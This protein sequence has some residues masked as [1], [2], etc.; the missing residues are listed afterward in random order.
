MRGKRKL[1]SVRRCKTSSI[2]A[3]VSVMLLS[4]TTLNPSFL[5]VA[6]AFA[7][8][9]TSSLRGMGSF[10]FS[11]LNHSR[12]AYDQQQQQQQQHVFEPIR[13]H[14]NPRSLTG[15]SQELV[16][17][18]VDKVNTSICTNSFVSLSLRGVKTRKSSRKKGRNDSGDETSETLRGS[19]RQVHGRLVR[20]GNEKKGGQQNIEDSLRLQLTLK[21]HLATD[22]VK[23]IDLAD[24][25]ETLTSLLLDA[26]E[27]SEWGVQAIRSNPLQ[28]ALLETTEAVW[29]LNLGSKPSI[30]RQQVKTGNDPISP[31]MSHDREKNVPL[32][33]GAEFLRMLGVTTTDG[34]PRPG[35]AS[36][37]RQ[38][39]RFVEIVA[40]LVEKTVRDE[41]STISVLDMGC[42]RGY[43]T[44]SLHSYLSE[45]YGGAALVE[46]TGVDV[47]PKLI[48]EMSAISEGL[49]GFFQ[50]LEFETGTIH[51]LVEKASVLDGPSE[52]MAENSSSVDILVALHACDTAT[53]D[54]IYS[55]IARDADVIVVA[56][57][58]HKELRPQ[59][60]L[61]AS[62]KDP[63][64]KHAIYR[65]RMAETVT[66]SLRAL[67]LERAGYKVQVFEFIGGEH[68]AKNVMITAVKSTRQK[69]SSDDIEERILSLASDYGIGSQ[70]LAQW[71]EIGLTLGSELKK[72][73]RQAKPKKILVNR[74]PRSAEK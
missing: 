48:A 18:F 20:L 37:L 17:L 56:P 7:S 44:F 27:A 11:R 61:H 68:T 10:H 57:C 49:G 74:M 23:N 70:K 71:M 4:L 3:L 39:Q 22:I 30:K 5:F 1:I 19:I 26:A 32:S 59:L 69:D 29:D 52:D 14:Q 16:K 6:D 43:L 65:E 15:Q 31:T 55:G 25:P 8:V 64:L 62:S 50:S 35:M 53:D 2:S 24:V 40:S 28:G 47:R 58:C 12:K 46:T 34:K 33:K 60:D 67:L 45:K 72:K 42:G 73:G 9:H 66:D 21:Y 36:K 54:A 63:I 41:T 13:Q 51:Q 38:C